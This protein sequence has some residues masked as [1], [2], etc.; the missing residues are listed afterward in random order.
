[1]VTAQD[2]VITK[3]TSMGFMT[4]TKDWCSFPSASGSGML[5]QL[6]CE[7]FSGK[8]MG[9]VRFPPRTHRRGLLVRL[10]FE[11]R[12][13][14][15]SSA[16]CT[17]SA[18]VLVESGSGQRPR[19]PAATA[20]VRP[21]RRQGALDEPVLLARARRHG[22]GVVPLPLC[23]P[24]TDPD[25]LGYRREGSGALSVVTVCLMVLQIVS[26]QNLA[27]VQER[28]ARLPAEWQRQAG[29]AGAAMPGPG[30]IR[31]SDPEAAR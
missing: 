1:M 29:P 12:A 3:I 5:S 21:R 4:C 25:R 16:A 7:R 26:E 27:G 17:S 19:R 20:P 13:A 30:D 6:G 28:A 22:L 14:T 11:W 24:V 31:R 23:D 15:R 2:I 18:T 8:L 9:K 10:A